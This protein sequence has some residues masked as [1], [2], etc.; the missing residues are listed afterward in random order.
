MSSFWKRIQQTV[1]GASTPETTTVGTPETTTVGTPSQWCSGA[2][3]RGDGVP[4]H[5]S[6]VPKV[7]N[8]RIGRWRS[9]LSSIIASL[10]PHPHPQCSSPGCLS[11]IQRLAFA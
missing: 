5:D 11:R 2:G 7:G 9:I 10:A 6:G 3:T 8:H 1:K 4:P